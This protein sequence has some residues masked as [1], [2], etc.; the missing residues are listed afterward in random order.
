MKEAFSFAPPPEEAVTLKQTSE[1]AIA[2]TP[3]FKK[4]VH[5][6][7][8][9]MRE[10]TDL[11]GQAEE[12][13]CREQSQRLKES[14]KAGFRYESDVFSS[15]NCSVTYLNR[16]SGMASFD[17]CQEYFKAQV[18]EDS[19]FIK[20]EKSS[21]NEQ[22]GVSELLVSEQVKRILKDFTDVEVVDYQFGFADKKNGTQYFVS[23]WADGLVNMGDFF[24][25][26]E[27][28]DQIRE[29]RKRI[30]QIKEALIEAGCRVYDFDV[31]NAFFDPETK[32]IVLFDLNKY[33]K[34]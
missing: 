32:K 30:N 13:V 7:P 23:K 16:F 8:G 3:D 12:V 2:Y 1:K 29:L 19:F 28:F 34:I 6:N 33:L 10:I 26:G 14:D 9:V 27:D 18:G 15:G 25:K 11:I 22:G 5:D 20:K 24:E 31:H 4:L 21:S 17:P